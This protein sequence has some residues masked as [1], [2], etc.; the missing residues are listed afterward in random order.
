M[1]SAKD[2]VVTLEELA[3]ISRQA[4]AYEQRVGLCHGVF[5]ILHIGHTRHFE[6]AKKEC[7]TLFVTITADS[8]VNKGP[9]N[10]HF[11]DH[12]R[13]EKI[14]ESMYVDFV[15][16]HYG[17]AAPI[18]E[19]KPDVYVKD[20]EYENPEDDI[21]GKIVVERAA[22]ESYGGRIVFTHEIKFSSSEILNRVP[23]IY[24]PPLRDLLRQY[25]AEN[26]LAAILGMLG[27]IKDMKVVMVGETI[28]DRYRYV[29]PLGKAAKENVIAAQLMSEEIFA[30]GVIAAANH[31]AEIV[32]EV[33]VITAI[34]NDENEAQVRHLI[35]RSL[36]PNV[37]V[38]FTVREDEPTTTKSRYVDASYTRK[39]FEVYVDGPPEYD[40]KCAYY[41]RQDIEKALKGAD[42]LTVLDYGHGMFMPEVREA[43]QQAK[44]LAIN[45]QTNA[46]NQGYNLI[47]KWGGGNYICVDAPEARL[48]I[49]D[50]TSNLNFLIERLSDYTGCCEKIII[51]AGADGCV[52]YDSDTP[53]IVPVPAFTSRVV[54]TMGAGDAFLAV[55]APLVAAGGRMDLVGFVGNAAGALKVGTVGHRQPIK[56]A[57]LIRYVS[58]PLK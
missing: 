10:P 52:T 53:R 46:G 3:E 32:G 50:R 35:K 9:G 43:C 30:G 34:G 15:A 47:T 42:V 2:K 58:S 23:N 25:R 28:I 54:D 41:I 22:V 55:T 1:K 48:A 38:L 36:R 49:G 51:T 17:T 26:A 37:R 12:I 4:K 44:F 24:E 33:E 45:A 11:P 18:A 13:A 19:I 16:I 6:A 20:A 8:F 14:A 57:D 29:K 56:K 27:R 39:L 31:V 5:D 21:T 40:E 7:E